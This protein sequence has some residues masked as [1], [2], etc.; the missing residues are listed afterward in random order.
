MATKSTWLLIAIS[1]GCAGLAGWALQKTLRGW[2][3]TK[4]SRAGLGAGAGFALVS[5]LACALL[6]YTNGF[7]RWQGAAD[8]V[9]TFFAYTTNPGH[10]KAWS[11]YLTQLLFFKGGF[12]EAAI[13]LP[14]LA[15]WAA[16]FLSKNFRKQAPLG[17]LWLSL[18]GAAQVIGYSLVAY[19]TPWLMLVPLAYLAPWAGWTLFYVGWAPGAQRARATAALAVLALAAM[20][21]VWQVCASQPQ[22]ESANGPAPFAYVPTSM[23]VPRLTALLLARAPAG[24]IAVVAKGEAIWPLPWYLRGAAKRTGYFYEK[25][26]LPCE[27]AAYVFVN[28][29]PKAALARQ[30]R[31]THESVY[32]TLFLPG[33]PFAVYLPK[34]PAK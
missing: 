24:D 27:F 5:A 4:I 29:A 11:Y 19:K 15:G 28:T 3:E 18:A 30:L 1:W 12:G 6:F 7:T 8:M 9:R 2:K 22:A 31:E 25:D 32:G 14:A 33:Q 13:T 26:A 23:D 17:L 21:D 20:F 16:L 34:A 10:D